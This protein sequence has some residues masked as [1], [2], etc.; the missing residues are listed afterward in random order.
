[1]YGLA[2]STNFFGGSL[3]LST[4]FFGG[5]LA[6]ST[7]KTFT[8]HGQMWKIGPDPKNRTL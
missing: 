7:R 6:L 8:I 4:N 1:M 5:S 3:A 2:L